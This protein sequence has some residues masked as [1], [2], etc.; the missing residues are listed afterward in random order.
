[1]KRMLVDMAK[2]TKG[3]KMSCLRCACMALVAAIVSFQAVANV[4]I[5]DNE[6]SVKAVTVPSGEELE[7]RGSGLTANCTLTLAGGAK[8]KFYTNATI[9]APVTV[10]GSVTFEA[11]ESVRGKVSG[12]VSANVGSS[13]TF[14]VKGAGTVEFAG[15]LT[16]NASSTVRVYDGNALVSAGTMSVVSAV[17]MLAGTLTF[18][19]ATFSCSGANEMLGM[20]SASQ[21]GDVKVTFLK[22][23]SWT[24]GNGQ[25]PRIGYVPGRESRL[26]LDGGTWETST[27]DTF[28]L[29]PSGTGIGIFE[30]KSGVFRTNRRIISGNVADKGGTSKVIWSGGT[31][32]SLK[33]TY[34]KDYQYAYIVQ[35][36]LS[37]FLI[38]GDCTL[39]LY[40]FTNGTVSFFENA[41]ARLRATPGARL[42]I[43]SESS[44]AGWCNHVVL[45]G[46]DANGL[47]LDLVRSSV[48]GDVTVD[49]PDVAGTVQ[50]GLVPGS[51]GRICATGTSPALNV[52]CPV[53]RNASLPS[54]FDSLVGF[55]SVTLTDVTV[56]TA[57]ADKTYV[58][59]CVIDRMTGVLTL[60]SGNLT[61][62]GEL[63]PGKLVV[64]GG[65][66]RY[67]AADPVIL[68]NTTK[69]PNAT[70]N[71]KDASDA[72]CG[73]T[74]GA[75]ANI[76]TMDSNGG[77][78][79]TLPAY[80]LVVGG[81]GGHS[82][83][84]GSG[85]FEIGA[86]GLEFT[87][88]K[89]WAL[90][91][92]VF[93]ERFLLTANQTWTNSAASGTAYM[94]LGFGY[95]APDYHK[96]Y[97]KAAPGVTDWRLGGNFETWLY[98]PSNDLKDV[99]VTISKPAT[100]R[101]VSDIDARLHAKKLVLDGA[102]MAFGRKF[103]CEDTYH[104]DY[105]SV[106]VADSDHVAPEVILR[107]GGK[108]AM[109][110]ESGLFAIPK[111][112]GVGA[113]NAV[114]GTVIPVAQEVTSITVASAGDE[115]AF[116]GIVRYPEGARFDVNGQGKLVLRA[117]AKGDLPDVNL[118]DGGTVKFVKSGCYTG[119]IAGC[120]TLEIVG[121]GRI[122]MSECDLSDSSLEVIEVAAGTLMLESGDDIP[123]GVKVR[124]TG[125]G[126]LLLADLTGFDPETRMEGTKKL[127]GAIVITDEPREGETVSVGAGETLLV[128]GN[129][130]KASSRVVLTDG[131][132]VVF[133]RSATVQSAVSTQ[134]SVTIEAAKGVTGK[135]TGAVS[136][137][138]TKT[139]SLDVTGAGTVE[140][141]GGV[142][143]GDF[144]YFCARGGNALVSSGTMRTAL[145]VQ[146]LAGTLTF[147]NATFACSGSGEM[148]NMA[149]PSQ[150]GDVKVTF[151]KGSSWTLGNGQSPRIGNV[152]GLESRL[153]LDGGTLETSTYD[154]FNLCPN[155]TGIGIFEMKSG[156][157]RTNR[158]IISGNV[159]DK[160]GTSK[161]I[162][163]GGTYTSVKN[164]YGRDYQYA[165]I[166]Q[167]PLS[168]FLIAGDCTLDLYRFTNGTVSFFENANARLRATPD[169]MLTIKSESS[170]AGWCNHVVLN[171]FD[172]N[173]LALNLVR[174]SVNGDVTVDIPD[175]TGTVELGWAIGGQGMVCATGTSPALVA[176]Y[177]VPNGAVFST[178]ADYSGW[179]TGFSS[180]QGND[181]VFKAGSRFEFQVVDSAIVPF[182]IAGTLKL[183]SAMSFLVDANVR[184]GALEGVPVLVAAEGVEGDCTWT[185]AGGL[186]KRASRLYAE[187]DAVKFDYEPKGM[188][189]LV[190]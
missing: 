111:V 148:I 67:A 190:K 76:D 9:A 112:S 126:A 113:G 38:A 91:H 161:V 183:P 103:P 149:S 59:G 92:K 21:F 30:M 25:S 124:T 28:N 72:A 134:G 40:R 71:W 102:E 117:T 17:Q 139:A 52:F 172:A 114:V 79:G 50:L 15:G 165:Y 98:S 121:D 42:T 2:K 142:T 110:D 160:G 120:G 188:A 153:V 146:M 189:I 32:T 171:G 31:L 64:K 152:Q 173:G 108:L 61:L 118:V 166:V 46:F 144:V 20:A 131:A 45:N 105:T 43:K 73:W 122:D 24:L 137:S 129:G 16:A 158:R 116:D 63:D 58:P 87:K 135:I 65:S 88:S 145:A 57:D 107:N 115:L 185:C 5:D 77:L 187:G 119:R 51:Q 101:L 49:I 19:N 143:A 128:C 163:S 44:T 184:P 136:A 29:C 130:L 174:S 69:W 123:E 68:R 155:G 10:Q 125:E 3:N 83:D 6:P 84:G 175:V 157:F 138:A 1:M 89:M 176:N 22:G 80:K 27:Y 127:V 70:S 78:D 48:N 60:E 141:T 62:D 95:K 81:N 99:T 178:T 56:A 37:E 147:S 82:W 170:T 41:N 39:D 93:L 90:L 106:N 97:M 182:E 151:L 96:G 85:R 35:G 156:V 164:T 140:F 109:D 34:G 179:N 14:D 168:E 133:G 169:A 162:W 150:F 75:V 74:A 94:Q 104:G 55:S 180:V 181:L 23:S 8:V 12:K 33:N 26:V 47:A 36:P 7:V 13:S 4:V 132:S 159:A 86:G 18:S 167:G 177:V 11:I 186:S 54:S 53:V 100:I 154:T 66:V